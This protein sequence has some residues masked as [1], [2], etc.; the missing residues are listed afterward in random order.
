MLQYMQWVQQQKV[1]LVSTFA[2]TEGVTQAD[3]DTERWKVSNVDT[4]SIVLC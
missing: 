1:K 3:I 2:D 4:L